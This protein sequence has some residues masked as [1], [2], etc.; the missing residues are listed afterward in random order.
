MRLTTSQGASVPESA[1]IEL[2]E[3]LRGPVITEEDQEYPA[4]K[5]IWNAYFERRPGAI[6]RVQGAADVITAVRFAKEHDILLAVTG[7]GHCFAGTGSCEGGLVIDTSALKGIRV[8]PERRTVQAQPGL[9]QGEFD[10]ETM[11]FGLAVTGSQESYIGIGG[12]T[13][14]GGLGWLGRYRGLLV[15][16]LLSA[17]IVLASGE[18]RRAGPEDDADLFW[19]IRGG[20]GNFGVATAFEYKLHPQGDCLAGLLA[21]PVAETGAVARRLG[22]FNESAPDALTTS[23][24]FLTVDGEPA[25]GLG[26]VHADTSAGAEEAVAP[27]AG[28]GRKPLLNHVGRMPYLAVQRM[29][30]DNTVAGRRLYARS[31]HMAE[32][33]PEAVE[34]LGD[35]YASNPSPLSLVGGGLMGGVMAQLPPDATAFP[36]REGYLVSVLSQWE[37]ESEDEQNIRW[38]QDVYE[39]VLPYT[40]GGVYVNHLGDDGPQRVGD[41]YGVNYPRLRA[42]K[43]QYDPE[44]VFRV[45]HN[46]LP[47]D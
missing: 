7:G 34:V 9:L 15:D 37:D 4:A 35:G 2:R 14:G 39:R 33:H 3:R 27:L 18:V 19:A 23:F 12:M 36:H 25:V 29:L 8:D 44:N 10:A 21:F 17:D 43:A 42:L 1:V 30:D 26:Y 13:L 28:L 22:E 11:H 31:F 24:A 20:G 46:I 5:A 40:T 38:T 32:L 41:A 45:N 16:N 47:A 6:V